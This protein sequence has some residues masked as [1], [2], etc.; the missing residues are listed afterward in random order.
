LKKLHEERISKQ[1]KDRKRT[2]EKKARDL[3]K[4]QL[5]MTAPA[6]L[7][8]DDRALAGEDEVFDLEA[9]EKEAGR[10][11]TEM[12]ELAE[13]DGMSE[14]EAEERQSSDDEEV[15]DSEEE[16][17][18]KLGALETELDGLYDDY[19]ERMAERDAK[20]KVKEARN[21]DKNYDAWH[22]IKDAS[23]SEDEAVERMVRVPRRGDADEDAGEESEE[24]G[25][26]VVAAHKATL[27]EEA[28]S[29]DDEDAPPRPALKRKAD[30]PTTAPR[31]R[32]LVTSLAEAEKRSQMSRHA[33]LWFDQSVFK[34]VDDLAALDADDEDEVADEDED[35]NMEDSDDEEAIAP[36]TDEVSATL[37]RSMLTFAGRRLLR[38]RSTG[39]RGGRWHAQLGRR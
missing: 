26:D 19:R 13:Q 35:V 4:L 16:R 38:D 39:T 10:L 9:G 8:N 6:D 5:H 12:A 31:S 23:G 27:G 22:G 1:R 24:G 36:K 2:N 17:E 25:W 20:W 21:K 30:R 11:G 14:D 29:S 34:G 37:C 15:F 33:Q 32:G 7:D 28:D 3:L 18:L